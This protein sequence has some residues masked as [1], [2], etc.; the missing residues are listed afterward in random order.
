MT[1]FARLSAAAFTF[2]AATSA[3][4]A[5]QPV[6]TLEKRSGAPISFFDSELLNAL[7][8]AL[9]AEP[10]TAFGCDAFSASACDATLVSER[11]VQLVRIAPAPVSFEA[12]AIGRA[13]NDDDRE[14]TRAVINRSTVFVLDR[15]A[16]SNPVAAAEVDRL[17][18]DE[19]ADEGETPVLENPLPAAA[20][21]LLAGLAG[22]A[23][24]GRRR[25]VA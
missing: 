13:S 16:F 4:A 23:L 1:L 24:V 21:I 2:V 15:N 7:T 20:P 17:T 3:A 9:S 14:P 11:T 6:I 22:L 10:R 12:P 18:A 8:R 5:P 19:A 25:R